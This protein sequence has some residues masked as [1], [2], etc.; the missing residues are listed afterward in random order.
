MVYINLT[1]GNA[2]Y[3]FAAKLKLLIF[4]F[5][6]FTS[7]LKA[8]LKTACSRMCDTLCGSFVPNEGDAVGCVN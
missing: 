2:V 3:L 6:K 7:F 4:P 5:S 1:I 8:C